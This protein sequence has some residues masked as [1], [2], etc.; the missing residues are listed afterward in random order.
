[1]A[2]EEYFLKRRLKSMSKRLFLAT[3]IFTAT[4]TATAQTNISQKKSRN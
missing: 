3:A 4:Q 1:M 2:F